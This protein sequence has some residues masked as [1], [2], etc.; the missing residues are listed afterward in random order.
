MCVFLRMFTFQYETPNIQVLIFNW[1]FQKCWRTDKEY[2]SDYFQARSNIVLCL[3]IQ[4]CD[5]LQTTQYSLL[6]SLLPR[7][8]V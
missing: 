2:F 4:L 3:T 7:N 6:D 5:N 8:L 1:V